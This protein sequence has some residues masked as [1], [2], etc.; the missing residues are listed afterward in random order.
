[1][2]G[3]K[4]RGECKAMVIPV[5][6]TV[7]ADDSDTGEEQRGNAGDY[8]V[9]YDSGKRAPIDPSK[10]EAEWG[11][12]NAGCAPTYLP[13][14]GQIPFKQMIEDMD[15]LR[16]KPL[17]PRLPRIGDH[18]YPGQLWYGSPPLQP[19]GSSGRFC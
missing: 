11:E 3:Y 12:I 14:I 7:P 9:E 1:M 2:K 19:W 18:D 17:V 15:R 4:R 5:P 6:F 10:F 8:L 13:Q 16:Q